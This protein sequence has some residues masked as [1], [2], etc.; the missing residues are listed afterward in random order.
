MDEIRKAFEAQRAVP[1]GVGWLDD[2]NEYSNLY[3]GHCEERGEMYQLLWIEFK[4]GAESR[5]AEVDRLTNIC[6]EMKENYLRVLGF[7]HQKGKDYQE[8]SIKYQFLKDH[9][10]EARR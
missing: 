8:L 1:N 10:I 9:E 4:A 2:S 3:E 7:L 6:A 5:Q